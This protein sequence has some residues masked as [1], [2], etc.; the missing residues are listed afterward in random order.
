MNEHKE[1]WLQPWCEGCDKDANTG[2][3]GGRQWCEDD[4][5]DTCEGCEQK[6]VRYVLAESKP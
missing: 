1:I 2:W 6:S 3:N 4:V 5:W